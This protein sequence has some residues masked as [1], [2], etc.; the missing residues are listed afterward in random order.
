MGRGLRSVVGRLLRWLW[1]LVPV[2]ALAL[3]RDDLRV[4]LRLEP[5]V[6]DPTQTPSAS[7]GEML[8]LNVLEG[9]T[10]VDKMGQVALR[11]AQ[12]WA[13]SPD[14][15]TVDVDLRHGVRFHDGT[16]LTADLVAQRLNTIV[17][18]GSTNPQK[19][20]FERLQR[21]QAT[22]PLSLRLVLS[23]PDPFL[24]FALALPAAAIVGPAGPDPELPVGTGPFKLMRWEKGR[25][26]HLMR[27]EEYW[28]PR[29]ALRTVQFV[30]LSTLAEAES[31]LMEG[32]ID[33]LANGAELSA[34]Y[35]IRPDLQVSPRRT[36]QKVLLAINNARAP[37]D[38]LRVRRALN[39]AIHRA[40]F[41]DFYRTPERARLIGSHFSPDHPAYVD[42]SQR[43]P[44]DPSQA[45]ALLRQ[46]GVKPG[47]TLTL[48]APP[49]L[50][51]RKG[52]LMIAQDLQAVGL[53]VNIKPVSWKEW[54]R[55]VYEKKD[56]QL[57]LIAHVEPMDINI[58][59][60]DDYYFNYR[61]AEFKAL[62]SQ[63]MR[64]RTDA[65]LYQGLRAAQRKIAD[66]AVNVFLFMVPQTNVFNRK[67]DGLW[68]VS[69]VPAFALED[70]HWRDE[71][72]GGTSPLSV[73]PG[74]ARHQKSP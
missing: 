7:A 58:Y 21:A 20:W 6:L 38:D 50:Y 73:R 10:F 46:A 15:L 41:G 43:Y 61:N 36:E 18:P 13:P 52:G 66:D 22:G 27:F 56:Y 47:L 19:K 44:H 72:N 71:D 5:P 65:E 30:F 40:A 54:L 3:P 25:A 11:L 69:P 74:P 12:R 1:C 17:A 2:L 68:D 37:L 28:G 26:L 60:R 34:Q 53:Q 67:L 63:V 24:R 4:G 31:A 70:A 62:W 42:L 16:P 33:G 59:A 14:G 23:A 9:L 45:R 51:A 57:T 32:L 29:P 48:I 8:H 35:V 55:Q 49:M 64:S 39:H